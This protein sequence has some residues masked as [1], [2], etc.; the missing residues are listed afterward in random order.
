M[1]YLYIITLH[2]QDSTS[3]LVYDTI[4]NR[5]SLLIV[6]IYIFFNVYYD[7]KYHLIEPTYFSLKFIYFFCFKLIFLN[8]FN[9]LILKINLKKIKKP[10]F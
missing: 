7:E 5:K 8:Y 9:I 6:E 3:F 10:L 1:V 4:F 2:H